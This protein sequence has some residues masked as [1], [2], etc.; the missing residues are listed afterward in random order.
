MRLIVL[1][2]WLFA[3]AWSIGVVADQIGGLTTFVLLLC[4]AAAGVHLIRR[5]GYRT[6]LAVQA[7]M[8]RQELPAVAMLDSLIVFLAGVLLIVPGFLSDALALVLLFS[9]LRRYFARRAEA[10]IAHRSPSFRDPTIIDGEFQQVEEF[11]AV[12]RDEN[13]PHD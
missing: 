9:G 11:T 13:K 4:I 3:E 7:S 5:Q 10:F 2:A 8:Q 12:E 6:L 1:I